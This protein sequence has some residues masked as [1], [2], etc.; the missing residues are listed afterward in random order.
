MLHIK[1]YVYH[2]VHT[3]TKYYANTCDYEIMIFS[4]IYGYH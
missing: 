1:V 2:I 4:F 3:S